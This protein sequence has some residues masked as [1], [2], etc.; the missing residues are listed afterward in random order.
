MRQLKKRKHL[1]MKRTYAA[2]APQFLIA[3]ESNQDK[4]ADLS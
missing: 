4:T 1:R 2:F 3:S